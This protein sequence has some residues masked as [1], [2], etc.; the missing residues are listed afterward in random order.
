MMRRASEAGWWWMAML[1]LG[2]VTVWFISVSASERE[3]Q[4]LERQLQ[5]S[6]Q[7]VRWLKREVEHWKKRALNE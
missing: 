6:E 1:I 7:N 2:L 4:D 3:K 5:R